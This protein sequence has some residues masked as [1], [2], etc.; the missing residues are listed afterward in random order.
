MDDVKD[1]ITLANYPVIE[2]SSGYPWS[3]SLEFMQIE[4]NYFASCTH[5]MK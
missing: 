3:I 5:K 2:G 4:V 1:L